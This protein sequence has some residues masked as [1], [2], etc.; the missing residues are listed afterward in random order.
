MISTQQQL[1]FFPEISALDRLQDNVEDAGLKT[2]AVHF[3]L[4]HSDSILN[5]VHRITFVSVTVKVYLGDQW[6]V[7]GANG[8]EVV[9]R[10][11]PKLG[12]A[13]GIWAIGNRSN[14]LQLIQTR[15]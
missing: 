9:M 12:R 10:A 14:A 6:F 7:T 2:D 8:N 13:G 4:L 3:V 11:A 5:P 1:F 15:F